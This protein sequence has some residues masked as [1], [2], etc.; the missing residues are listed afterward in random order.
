MCVSVV[1]VCVVYVLLACVI[2][3]SIVCISVGESWYLLNSEGASMN[4]GERKVCT[5]NKTRFFRGCRYS[6]EI[7]AST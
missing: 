6:Y 1:C 3:R 2:K 5:E 4:R 7:Q